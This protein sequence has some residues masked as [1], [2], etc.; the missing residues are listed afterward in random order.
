MK[1]TFGGFVVV[2]F[3]GVFFVGGSAKGVRTCV[4][5]VAFLPLS[6]YFTGMRLHFK[7]L[8]K[9]LRIN[10]QATFLYLAAKAD[11]VSVKQSRQAPKER[12]LFK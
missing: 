11:L 7:H 10:A 2:C 12:G 4:C 5:C 6:E 8:D 3:V 1:L 9:Y